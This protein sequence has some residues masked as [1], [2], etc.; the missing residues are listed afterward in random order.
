MSAACDGHK[1]ADQEGCS[2]SNLGDNVLPLRGPHVI[3]LGAP[4][5]ECHNARL[6]LGVEAPL[7][8]KDKR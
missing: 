6:A 7:V 8:V 2:I 3:Q 4:Q 5:D 1:E